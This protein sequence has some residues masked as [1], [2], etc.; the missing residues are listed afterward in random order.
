[1]YLSSLSGSGTII[2]QNVPVSSYTVKIS[3]QK[4]Y[5]ESRLVLLIEKCNPCIVIGMLKL[6]LDYKT[7]ILAECLK[8]H[9]L[10]K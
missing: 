10:R 8:L 3:S 2:H 1:M 4:M 5:I 9:P 7:D 6:L